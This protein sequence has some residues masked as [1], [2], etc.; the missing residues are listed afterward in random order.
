MDARFDLWLHGASVGDARALG[1]L[2][3]RLR[4]LTPA[5]SVGMTVGRAA[6]REAATRWYPDVPVLAP[7]LPFGLTGGRFLRRRGVR[8]QVLEYLELWPGWVRACA[9]AGVPVVVVDGR[10]SHRSLRVRAL[11]RA[12]AARVDLFC[13]QT[14]ED[15][16]AAV[17]LGVPRDRVHVTGNGKHDRVFDPPAPSA[18]LRA[19][20]GAVDLVV[21]SLNPREERAA[22]A[23][24]AA[25]PGR[26]LWAPRYPARAAGLCRRA[27]AA[28]VDCAL[29]TRGGAGARWIVLDTIGELAAAWA[30]GRVAL[31]GGTFCRREGQNLVEAAAHGLPVVHGP[32]VANVAPEAR[33]LAG[34]GAFAVDDLAGA[35]DR[36]RALLEGRLPAP[37]P[38]PALAT[39]RGAA[40]RQ[41]DLMRPILEAVADR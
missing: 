36:V 29:R 32:R 11:L 35:A 3:A 26:I 37:D 2:L 17:T 12:T 31:A 10:V 8:L 25:F 6:G 20:V 23:A 18:E 41:V 1:P 16:E 27:R 4:G 30:L 5:P 21:G 7:P 28:G 19:A 9:R 33:A 34:R 24:F 22:V 14:P 15:A 38:R 39:L 40:D 13:A